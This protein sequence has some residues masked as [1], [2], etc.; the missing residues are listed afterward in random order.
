MDDIGNAL[1]Q[2]HRGETI[3]FICS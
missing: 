3:S 2:N 1:L